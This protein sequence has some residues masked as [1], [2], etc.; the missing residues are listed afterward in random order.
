MF[1]GLAILQLLIIIF[2]MLITQTLLQL[3]NIADTRP[4]ILLCIGTDRVTGDCFGPLVGTMLLNLHSVNT[5]IYGTLE[6]PVTALNL[7]QTVAFIKFKHPNRTILAIDSS[8]GKESD[9]GNIRVIADGIYPGAATG[10]NL[11][12]V[13]DFSLTA[14]IAPLGKSSLLYGVRLGFVHKLAQR[15]AHAINLA[16]KDFGNVAIN[17]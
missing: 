9:V 2:A 8:L 13:G 3:F 14:T 16:L 1:C 10:K 6:N 7:L 17:F 5:Y 4:P 12:K 15:A 11:P